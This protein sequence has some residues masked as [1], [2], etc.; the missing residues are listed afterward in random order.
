MRPFSIA[1]CES[2]LV[3]MSWNELPL[4]RLARL[5]ASPWPPHP[6]APATP[7]RRTVSRRVI[8]S[9]SVPRS[10]PLMVLTAAPRSLCRKPTTVCRF[11]RAWSAMAEIRASLRSWALMYSLSPC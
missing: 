2:A 5:G 4:T 9:T 3:R 11:E 1:M 10:V 8:V 7:G 6:V